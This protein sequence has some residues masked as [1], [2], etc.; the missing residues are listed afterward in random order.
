M[1]VD[2]CDSG[3]KRTIGTFTDYE[4]EFFGL[5][6]TNELMI[7]TYAILTEM[8]RMTGPNPV[9]FSAKAGT[10]ASIISH[11]F[12][13][14]KTRRVG[15]ICRKAHIVINEKLDSTVSLS[16]FMVMMLDDTTDEATNSINSAWVFDAENLN[17]IKD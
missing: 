16:D 9:V 4:V 10:T 15:P 7:S 17:F 14:K 13:D 1:L 6:K 5:D 8:N 2:T 3:S 11:T 12:K